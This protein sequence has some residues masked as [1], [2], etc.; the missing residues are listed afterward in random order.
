[1]K[2]EGGKK[3]NDDEHSVNLLSSSPPKMTSRFS[4]SSTTTMAA[5]A[6]QSPLV[7]R[8]AAG[9]RRVPGGGDGL[10]SPRNNMS[11]GASSA[12]TPRKRPAR[13]SSTNVPPESPLQNISRRNSLLPDNLQDSTKVLVPLPT[14]AD[15]SSW[16]NV[17]LAFALLPALG[18]IL[19]TD[20]S[21]FIT[22]VI[23]IFLVAVFLHWLV[24]FPW[25]VL[26]EPIPGWGERLLTKMVMIGSGTTALMRCGTSEMRLTPWRH[27]R[28]S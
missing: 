14:D 25:F 20:G 18:G 10:R 21:Y 5:A 6:A 8:S 27:Q 24:K 1:M 22:D 3:K 4:T 15:S 16:H 23:L 17:P 2:G 7:Y 11:G 12:G 26:L 13:S 19:F 28:G 9:A